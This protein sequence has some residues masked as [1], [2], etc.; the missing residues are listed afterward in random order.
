MELC[1]L[2][3]RL[4]GLNSYYEGVDDN[5]TLI[6][7][8][9][10]LMPSRSMNL[11][12][13]LR[14]KQD[15]AIVRRDLTLQSTQEEAKSSRLILLLVIGLLVVSVLA[16][17]VGRI[18]QKM[19]GGDGSSSSSFSSSFSSESHQNPQ[20]LLGLNGLLGTSGKRLAIQSISGL[21]MVKPDEVFC[22]TF[23]EDS[24]L[25]LHWQF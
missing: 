15:T 11:D 17:V 24:L 3:Q 2:K 20:D 12:N 19:E 1:G 13:E 8:T 18:H 21:L 9:S 7:S 16:L 5:S 22:C 25:H 10:N 4:N 14:F 6:F 23:D